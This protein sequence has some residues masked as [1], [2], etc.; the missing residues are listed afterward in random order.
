MVYYVVIERES[1]VLC[2]VIV[3]RYDLVYVYS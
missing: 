2:N 1:F 3:V